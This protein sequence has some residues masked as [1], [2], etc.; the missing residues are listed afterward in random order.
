MVGRNLSENI[1]GSLGWV[2]YAKGL[3]GMA[4]GNVGGATVYAV[5]VGDRG[6]DMTLHTLIVLIYT[7]S[8]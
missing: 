6:R 2:L 8:I 3:P 4:K 5:V 1:M 7:A